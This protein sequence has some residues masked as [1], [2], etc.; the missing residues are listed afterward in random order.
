MNRIKHVI[1]I[2]KE[3]RTYDQILG[4]LE[5]DGKPVGNGDP[6]LTM[7]RRRRS[8]RTCTSWRCSLACSTTSTT[9]AK[10]RAT[11]TSGRM[12]PSARTIWRRPGSSPIAASERTYDFEGVV[13]DGYPLLQKIPDVNEPASGYLWG[14]PRRARQDLLPLRR[15]HFRRSSATK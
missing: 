11:G 8:R 5:Q 13:A 6:S 10:C 4:D 14:D 7:Y 9:R 1:Y 12:R 15:V 2:I 3:N